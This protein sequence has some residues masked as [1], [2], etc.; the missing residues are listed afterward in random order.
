MKDVVGDGGRR[1]QAMGNKRDQ[2]F[3]HGPQIF[4]PKFC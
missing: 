1:D 4:F 3:D 2:V